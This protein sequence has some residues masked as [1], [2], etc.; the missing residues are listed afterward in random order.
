MTTS[1]YMMKA[2]LA[3]LVAAGL[4]G[5]TCA[6]SAVTITDVE[7]VPNPYN[8]LSV[9]SASPAYSGNPISGLIL[10]TTSGGQIIP[11]FCVDLFHEIGIGG[12]Q[13][14]PYFSAPVTTDSSGSTSG[15]GNLLSTQQMGAIQTLVN[16]GFGDYAHNVPNL[17]DNLTALQGAIWDIEYGA[18]VTSSDGA[19]NSLIGSY[20][21]YGWDH[22]AAFSYGLYPVGPNGQG[23]GSSQGFVVGVPEASTWAMMLLGFAGL[24]FAGSRNVKA[25]ALFS[26]A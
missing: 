24:G 20:V 7:V 26:E 23:F 4:L 21:T 16:I 13:S 15:S 9:N 10:L 18:I 11:V 14:I 1:R 2:K 17:G 5:M 19:I 6:A 22:P 12:G 3:G 25:K 8:T